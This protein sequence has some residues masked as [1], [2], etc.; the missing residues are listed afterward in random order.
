M[1]FK[2]FVQGLVPDRKITPRVLDVFDE[3]LTH[4]SYNSEVN[5]EILET[6]GDAALDLVAAEWLANNSAINP[7]EISDARSKVVSNAN[8]MRIAHQMGI[9]EWFRT[10]SF[11]KDGKI[12][13]KDLA[14]SLEAIIGAIKV[15]FGFGYCEGWVIKHFI[16]YFEK[17]LKSEKVNPEKWGR[18]EF[19]YVNILQEFT[20]DKFGILPAYKEVIVL[21][22]HRV[23]CHIFGKIFYANGN[24]KKEAK[25]KAAEKAYKDQVR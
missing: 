5:Y 8:L 3:A 23:G 14:D 18:S 12:Y 7:R 25:K 15:L 6:I 16:R 21:R 11:K 19:N 24:N 17:S 22:G 2:Q 13:E 20:Q 1:N 9:K 4:R 10:N